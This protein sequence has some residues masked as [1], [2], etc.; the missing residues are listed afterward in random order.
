MAIGTY[1]CRLPMS[2][3]VNVAL[4]ALIQVLYVMSSLVIYL[5]GLSYV[6]VKVKVLHQLIYSNLC[7]LIL[8]VTPIDTCLIISGFRMP[9]WCLTVSVKW[10]IICAV[11]WHVLLHFLIML[12]ISERV[13][14]VSL[15]VE[16]KPVILVTS[17]WPTPQ[18][19]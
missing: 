4:L 5:C 13:Q 7:L 8:K 17:Q 14:I 1:M 9:E 10:W 6:M 2:M 12:N 11:S 16:L 15:M 19:A 18:K 3:C